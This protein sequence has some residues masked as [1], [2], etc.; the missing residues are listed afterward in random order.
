MKQIGFFIVFLLF[1]FASFSQQKEIGI[2]CRSGFTFEISQQKNWGYAKP[3]VLSVLPNTP[4]EATGLRV[5]DIIESI[6]GEPT[7]GK[8]YATIFSWLQRSA[9]ERILINIS[10]LKGRNKAIRLTP[11][12][13]LSNA[14]TEKDLAEV[15]AF[16]SLEDAQ[17]RS[18]TCPFKTK[19]SENVNLSNY[20][21]FGFSKP[22][23]KNRQLE[24]IIQVSVRK[25]LEQK[26]LVYAAKKPDL[27]LESYYTYQKNPNYRST[28][29]L[30]KL[31][32]ESRYNMNT[33]RMEN[34]PIYY[35]PLIHT[36]QA[37]YF[38]KLNILLID[39]NKRDTNRLIWEC[40]ANELLQS[41]YPI[42]D[43]A[44]FHIPLMLTQYPY[45]KST[46]QVQ[47]FYSR[48]RYNYTGIGYNMDNLKE[49]IRVDHATPAEEAGML[50]GDVVE[51]INGIKFNNNAKS[52]DSKYKQFILNTMPFRNE[53]TQFTNAE[54]FTKC[55]Y[56][57]PMDY[58]RVSDAIKKT[59]FS[60]VFSYLFY[61][62]PYINLSGSNIVSFNIVRGKQ[63]LT[64]KVK[65]VIVEEELFENR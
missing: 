33:K 65:P 47:F 32:V 14:I 13:N 34:L 41:D 61:F 16:Y 17:S 24:N 5:H 59:E 62:E 57:N 52:A 40:E 56:W 48:Y 7:E 37:A 23:A 21:T 42:E 3:V 30:K 45:L 27:L 22:D 2:T 6:N 11:Y 49:I 43:Y 53:K 46:D 19:V 1:C 4:A 12:C 38:L 28:G 51:K 10:N 25:C 36:N 58:V 60:A 20:K 63:K 29:S 44:D 15:Y 50:T 35:N 26:G 8:D 54:G 9:N 39:P 18:F 55:M 31:P 64:I